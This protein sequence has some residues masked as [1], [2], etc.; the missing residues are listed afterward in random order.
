MD[1]S[2]LQ[3][4]SP[5]FI[6]LLTHTSVMLLTVN[7]YT[8]LVIK[9]IKIENIGTNRLLTSELEAERLVAAEDAPEQLLCIGLILPQLA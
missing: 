8:E 6:Y 1:T 2:C 7:F 9:T 5:D 3:V 4:C